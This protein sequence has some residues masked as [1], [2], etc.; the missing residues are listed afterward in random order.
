M[1]RQ[2]PAALIGYTSKNFWLL[3]IPLIRGLFALRFD[4]KSWLEGAGWDVLVVA[5][6]IAAAVVRWY[7]TFYEIGENGVTV[8]EGFLLKKQFTVGFDK[9][10]AADSPESP[11]GR[12]L[13]FVRVRIDTDA[14][15]GGRRSADI[16]IVTDSKDRAR[17]FNILSEK[18][19]SDRAE[20]P[21][22]FRYKCSLLELIIFS[23]LFSSAFSGTA[24][25][26]TFL[27]GGTK[28]IGEQLEE[29]F[30]AAVDQVSSAA[31]NFLERLIGSISPA[32]IAIS[33][34]I[35]AGFLVSFAINILRHV[36]FS[37]SRRGNSITVMGGAP[38]RRICC[39]DSERINFADLRQNLLMKLFRI[40]SVHVS[41]TGYG[42][43][44]HDIPVF[45][46]VCRLGR[47]EGRLP[48]TDSMVKLLFTGFERS[49]SMIGTKIGSVFR[50]IAPA[51]VIVIGLPVLGML[52]L[53]YF[54]DWSEL[55]EF[56][57][58]VLEIPA[59]WY[60][61]AKSCAYCTTGVN[62]SARGVTASYCRGF[63]FHTVMIPRER[64]AHIKVRQTIF[65]RITKTCDL[66]IYTC[67]ESV[68]R[69]KIRSL[70]EAEIAQLIKER[71]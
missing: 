17:I 15:T 36:N 58:V 25:L 2:H 47:K 16:S 56:L 52:G 48:S 23:L 29:S 28:I 4:L 51:A 18:L 60:L 37:V 1:K 43:R 40:S 19:S 7:F 21:F 14:V 27:S 57:T 68:G 67:S 22:N 49:D 62:I 46:P 41:C 53:M 3:L 70:P 13:G 45:V 65:Q 8:K 42:K 39:I 64:I 69:H 35:G 55:I 38:V 54:T 24:L 71:A 12:W 44:K 63:G 20:N 33:V 31:V 9:I 6:M 30:A 34:V 66:I 26:I 50:F 61:L 32:G 10:S 5:V 59:V 11:L